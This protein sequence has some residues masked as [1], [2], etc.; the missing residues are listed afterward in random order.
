MKKILWVIEHL[1][2]YFVL[3]LLYGSIYFIIE[4]I[5]KGHLTHGM[6]F[7]VGGIIGVLIGMINNLFDMDTDFILQC[8]VGMMIVLITEC[9]VGYQFNIVQG[10]AMWDYSRVPFNFVGGQICIPFAIVWFILSGVCIVLD[11]WLRWRLFDEEEPF[12]IIWNKRVKR[13]KNK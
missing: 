2:K 11:D 7:L 8:L 3:F 4:S 5:Y 1:A 12:Y 10:M 6:M 13:S 9:I